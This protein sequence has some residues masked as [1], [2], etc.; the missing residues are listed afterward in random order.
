MKSTAVA[1]TTIENKL[2]IFIF[3]SNAYFNLFH[4]IPS[5]VTDTTRLIDIYNVL[6]VCNVE[7]MGLQNMPATLPN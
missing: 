7:A 5:F 2:P 6:L 4:S 1:K 3:N